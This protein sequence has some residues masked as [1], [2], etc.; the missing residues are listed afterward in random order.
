MLRYPIIIGFLAV[1][2]LDAEEPWS[3]SR[4][5]PITREVFTE[6]IKPEL[7]S[8]NF[9]IRF[10]QA[11]ISPLSGSTCRYSPTCSR[12]TAEAIARFGLLKGIVMGTDR[13]IRCHPGQREYPIDPP[14][15]F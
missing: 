8:T 2:L 4:E 3:I 15:D 6:Q 7:P 12:Y 11:Y 5:H 1:T 9:V 13:L 14:R 10:Y